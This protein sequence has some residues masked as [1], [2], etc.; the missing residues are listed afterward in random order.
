M[1]LDPDVAQALRRKLKATG[2]SQKE[3]MNAAL[4]KG[5]PGVGVGK[6]KKFNVIARPMGLRPEYA[7]I[8]F[9]RLSDQLLEE[10]SLRQ[11]SR[12]LARR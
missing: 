8:S 10:D 3:I 9:N 12:D 4:R 6:K 5:L 2:Q 1:T 7:G 11:R